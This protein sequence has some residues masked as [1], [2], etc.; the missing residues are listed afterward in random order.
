VRVRYRL[1]PWVDS[2]RASE[3]WCMVSNV[4][5]SQRCSPDSSGSSV[6]VLITLVGLP[7]AFRQA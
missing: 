6:D 4:A 3:I 5:Q 7:L 1:R 2:S